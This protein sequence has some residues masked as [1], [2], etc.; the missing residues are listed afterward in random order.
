[1]VVGTPSGY[2][3]TTSGTRVISVAIGGRVPEASAHSADNRSLD[4]RP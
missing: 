3:R 4:L 2:L 1:M